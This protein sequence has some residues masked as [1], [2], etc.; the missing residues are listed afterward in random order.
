MEQIEMN[1]VPP[2]QPIKAGRGTM[3]LVLGLLSI[4]LGITFCFLLGPA[5]GIPAWVMGKN[6]EREIKK[7]HISSLELSSTKG[8][9]VCG[10]IGTAFGIAFMVLIFFGLIFILPLVLS[11]H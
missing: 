2:S 4:V 1:Q 5:L 9:K 10:I 7:G 3:I 8:G 6:D 11:S